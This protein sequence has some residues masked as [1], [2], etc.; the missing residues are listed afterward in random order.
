MEKD[1]KQSALD[2]AEPAVSIPVHREELNVGTRTVD[3]GR[4]V[5][6]RTTVL[7]RPQQIDEVLHSDVISVEHVPV[8][9]I[10]SLEDAPASRYEGDTLI[11]PIL[12]EVLVVERRL[13]IKEEIHITKSRRAQRHSE[14]V[15][16]KSEEVVVER[17]D[18]TSDR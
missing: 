4:G 18:D 6:V 16:L 2:A 3:T 1:A 11:V 7:E 15:S 17:F 8:D 14:T 13:R 10:V 9:K 5:R 12:E